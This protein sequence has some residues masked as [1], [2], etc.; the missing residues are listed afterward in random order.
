MLFVCISGVFAQTPNYP[1]KPIKIISPYVPGG[2]NDTLARI[3]SDRLA[4]RF[5]IRVLVENRPGA[6]TIVGTEYVVNQPADGYTL[7]LLPN[8]FA[9]NAGFYPKLP[10]DPLADFSPIAQIAQSP[11]LLVAHPSFPAKS[12]ADLVRLAKGNREPIIFGSSGNGSMGHLAGMLF[13]DMTGSRLAHV[14]YKGASQAMTE[15][16]GGHIPLVMTSILAAL[17]HTKSG[18]LR[19]IGLTSAK[20][21]DAL[22]DIPTISEAGVRG[23][24]AVLWYGML[25]RANTPETIVKRINSELGV[26]LKNNQVTQ[27]L[28]AQA[29]EPHH[30]S[31]E[32]FSA[33]I[34]G[35]LQ[36]WSKLI[37]KSGVQLE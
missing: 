16:S 10:Y 35:E 9:T 28:T 37:R 33:L 34:K 1:V 26:V 15:V 8:S 18:R 13:S 20:R 19:I 17:P 11:Q 3:L 12:A 32:Q 23:Y 14:G 5:G 6:N 29:V 22:P 21:S 25:A 27:L 36:K 24:E 31:S 30:S 2:G 4:E 7:I